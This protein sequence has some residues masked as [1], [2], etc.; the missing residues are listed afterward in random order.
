MNVTFTS[1]NQGVPSATSD[2]IVVSPNVADHLDIVNA[3]SSTIAGVP[4]SF[5]VIVHDAFDNIVPD[6]TGTIAFNSND[7]Q[8]QL[9]G[10]VTFTAR[11]GG[12]KTLTATLDTVIGPTAGSQQSGD[13]I[14]ATQVI[15]GGEGVPITTAE[16]P[17]ITVLAAAASRLTITNVSTTLTAG[18]DVSFTVTAFDPF[19]NLATTNPVPLTFT[20]DDPLAT[21]PADTVLDSSGSQTF[22]ALFVSGGTK[23]LTI[24]E[25]GGPAVTTSAKFTVQSI[26]HPVGAV[27]IPLLNTPFTE[28]VASFTSDFPASASDFTAEI[29]W[30]DKTFSQG[31]IVAN[32]QGGFDV[33]GSHEYFKETTFLVDVTISAPSRRTQETTAPSAAVVL[34]I[35]E[36]AQLQSFDFQR[37]APGQGTLQCVTTGI[38][39]LLQDPN[40]GNRIMTLFVARY[41]GNPSSQAVDSATFFD[42]RVTG[43]DANTT[44]T[45]N[46]SFAGLQVTNPQLMVFDPALNRF[47]GVTD[48]IT[49][50]P[51]VVDMQNQV[52]RVVF[53][54][55]SFP[56]LLDLSN[57][58]FAIPAD[59]ALTATPVSNVLFVQFSNS[60]TFVANTTAT[61]AS[62]FIETV[63]STA[64]GELSVSGVAPASGGGDDG[65][66]GSGGSALADLPDAPGIIAPRDRKLFISPSQSG[67]TMN[68]E[69][70]SSAIS[71]PA[72][73]AL[74]SQSSAPVPFVVDR[75]FVES[76]APARVAEEI[77]TAVAVAVSETPG[78]QDTWEHV[79]AP[80]RDDSALI[81]SGGLLFG[82]SALLLATETG[83][84]RRADL[85][86]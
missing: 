32:S 61:I 55:K 14:S 52:I 59:G 49:L 26:I 38:S 60:T 70:E 20:S 23:T 9:P 17:L 86:I 13:F 72:S 77:E 81:A 54:N 45:V 41:Q 42:A 39:G 71:P 15:T 3:P 64:A 46:F 83:R 19:G 53:N 62:T 30:G 16:P 69:E 1:S 25:T 34:N 73:D 66:S 44:L 36:G 74:A 12:V 24:S 43:A 78:R 6:F 40:P 8:A 29:S 47:V 28:K 58:V 51:P 63:V 10:P 37:G 50:K 48:G 31:T 22:T 82:G 57:T 56:Q 75:V 68:E 18:T 35:G 76:P 33:I 11:D 21:L 65:G 5:T 85:M 27:V 2:P 80:Q 67:Q 7:P 84:R 79:F 4:F